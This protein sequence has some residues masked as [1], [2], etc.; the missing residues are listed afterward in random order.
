MWGDVRACAR[1]TLLAGNTRR[2]VLSIP[3]NDWSCADILQR[4]LKI[5]ENP[6]FVLCFIFHM[7]GY[8]SNKPSCGEE[9]MRMRTPGPIGQKYP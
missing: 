2:Y 3:Y 8:L 4:T 6:I 1:Q 7:K 9:C 5:E